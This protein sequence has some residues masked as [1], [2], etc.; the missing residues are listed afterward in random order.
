MVGIIGK[1]I[2]MTQVFNEEGIVTAVTVVEVTPMV[3]AQI[4]TEKTDGYN[5]IQVASGDVKDKHVN[6][7]MKGHFNKAGIPFKKLLKEFRVD[8]PSEFQVGQAI[9]ADIFTDGQK[10]DVT[11]T[12]KGKGTTGPIRRYNQSRGPETHG[13]KYHRGG[14]SIGAASYPARVFKGMPMAGRMGNEQVTV[15]NLE[16]VKVDAERNLLLIKG[17]VPG[18]KKG[19]ITIRKAIK[20]VK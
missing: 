18:P 11:G 3:V 8:N 1:K 6:K 14:G 2:G 16:V 13:S 19:R 12:S 7:P 15:L 4:K 5:A 17:A 9:T 10:I 20:A